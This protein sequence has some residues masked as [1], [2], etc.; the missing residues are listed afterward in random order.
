MTKIKV[1]ATVI[2]LILA[3]ILLAPLANT[4]LGKTKQEDV[5]EVIVTVDFEPT[6]RPSSSDAAGRL[7]EDVVIQVV[8]GPDKHPPGRTR[9]SPWIR[10]FFVRKG[11]RVTVMAQQYYGVRIGCAISQAGQPVKHKNAYGP[12]VITCEHVVI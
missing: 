3:W 10:T 9:N 2:G 6:E 4:H 11:Q 12:A 7:T 5:R 8:T 1:G